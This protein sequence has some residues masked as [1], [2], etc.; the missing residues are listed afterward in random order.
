M[1]HLSLPAITP[2][3]SEDCPLL[4]HLLSYVTSSSAISTWFTHSWSCCVIKILKDMS[5]GAYLES[6]GGGAGVCL[7]R[8][9]KGTGAHCSKNNGKL[10]FVVWLLNLAAYQHSQK[11]EQQKRHFTLLVPNLCQNSDSCSASYLTN[12]NTQMC[13]QSAGILQNTSSLWLQILPE[14]HIFRF[15]SRDSRYITGTAFNIYHL[16]KCPQI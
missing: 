15:Q 6:R 11:R 5:F 13:H 4:V 9:V 12:H 14:N 2:S 3:I 10:F 1:C 16:P 8:E 7:P